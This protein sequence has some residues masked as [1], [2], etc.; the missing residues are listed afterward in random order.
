MQGGIEPY[1]PECYWS[2]SVLGVSPPLFGFT[3]YT[4]NGLDF[5]TNYQSIANSLGVYCNN[6]PTNSSGAFDPQEVCFWYLGSANI[7]D[8]FEIKDYN[9]DIVPIVWTQT[10]EKTCWENLYPKPDFLIQQMNIYPFVNAIYP[11]STGGLNTLNVDNPVQVGAFQ[12]WLQEIQPTPI[13]T[14]NFDLDG[15]V[16]VQIRDVYFPIG[17]APVLD[18]YAGSNTF[19]QIDC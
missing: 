7:G 17:F 4:I 19:Y 13:V 9:G 8:V 1:A 14:A 3:G 18:N 2:W 15:N 12:T 6:A 10:C 5:L 16:I 11:S